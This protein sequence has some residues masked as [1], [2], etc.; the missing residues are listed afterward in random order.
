MLLHIDYYIIDS[1]C[2][3]LTNNSFGCILTTRYFSKAGKF[4]IVLFKSTNELGIVPDIWIS[5]DLCAW[6]HQIDKEVCV[7]KRIPPTRSWVRYEVKQ[8]EAY[9]NENWYHVYK[10]EC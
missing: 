3:N 2:L 5:N 4:V 7:R 8:Y 6:P 9:G 10:F 1:I